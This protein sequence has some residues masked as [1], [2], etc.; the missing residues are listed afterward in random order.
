MTAA[1][2]TE[3]ERRALA[4]YFRN[5]GTD[6]PLGGADV[7]EHEGKRYVVLSNLKGTLAVYRVRNNGMLKGMRRPPREI[8]T[9]WYSDH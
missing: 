6:Q 2:D 4:A 5:G 9:N 1:T 3:L 7:V 8:A